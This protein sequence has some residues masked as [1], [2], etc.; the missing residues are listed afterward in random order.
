MLGFETTY[1][2]LKRIGRQEVYGNE[3]FWDYL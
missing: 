3:E 2:E 1:K